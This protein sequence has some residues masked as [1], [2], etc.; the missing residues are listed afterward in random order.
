MQQKHPWETCERST[1]YVMSIDIYL[2]T[3]S[4]KEKSTVEFTEEG[5]PTETVEK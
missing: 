5:L 3:H 1:F 4:L 2:A